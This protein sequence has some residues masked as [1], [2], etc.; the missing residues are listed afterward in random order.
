MTKLISKREKIRAQMKSRW[1]YIF[2]GSATLAVVA[3]QI[4]VG[5]G[6]RRMADAI[7]RVLDA[8]LMIEIPDLI[9]PELLIPMPNTDPGPR[10]Y[11]DE[12][13]IQ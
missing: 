8:P 13:V 3:G 9:P 4:Y 1:Y 2:W 12:M 10:F 11:Q 7:Q 5:S 6:F